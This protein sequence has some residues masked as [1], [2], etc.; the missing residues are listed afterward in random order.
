MVSRIL[1][2]LLISLT[3]ITSLSNFNFSVDYEQMMK[4]F[5]HERECC[6]FEPE[7]T[8]KTIGKWPMNCEFVCGIMMFNENFDV[9]EAKMAVTLKNLKGLD[10]GI[11]VINSPLKSLSFWPPGFRT[12][13]SE[14]KLA[15]L[16]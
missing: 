11:R 9:P 7:I 12:Y 16:V 5:D 13:C 3:F 1:I 6:F 14:C 4:R 10:G 8:M 15:Y 2:Y